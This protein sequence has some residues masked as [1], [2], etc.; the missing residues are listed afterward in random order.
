MIYRGLESLDKFDA[1]K[2]AEKLETENSKA[3]LGIPQHQAAATGYEAFS[4][5]PFGV[6]G[7]K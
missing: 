3:E 1:A 7:S 5:N 6:G 4:A 2:E